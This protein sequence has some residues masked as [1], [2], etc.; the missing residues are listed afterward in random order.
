MTFDILKEI[1]E[2]EFSIINYEDEDERYFDYVKGYIPVLISAPHGSKH[3]RIRESRWKDEDAYTS[4]MAIVL[5][6]LT[7]AHVLFVRNKANEDPNNDTNTRYKEFLSQVVKEHNIKFVL[8]L[9]GAHGSHP[10]K[11]DIGTMGDDTEKG[12]CPTFKTL[13][14]NAFKDFQH[15]T[16]FNQRFSANG[17]G[18]VTCFVR[19]N[20]GIEA[21]QIEINA[22]YRIV[23]SKSSGFRA[24]KENVLGVIARLQSLIGAVAG[25]IATG[26]DTSSDAS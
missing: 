15:K 16:V 4:S 8:D 25:H 6:Q 19:R 20:L 22:H 3:Y 17:S 24:N 12:S 26:S 7:G 21:A 23:E 10:F 1:R 5:G 9:H 11:V 2:I 13:I 14:K 18:T